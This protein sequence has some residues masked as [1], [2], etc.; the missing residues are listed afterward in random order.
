MIASEY[1]GLTINISG[2][3][4]D[5]VSNNPLV[6]VFVAY[7]RDTVYQ[8]WSPLNHLPDGIHDWAFIVGARPSIDHRID[9][10]I[11]IALIPI[12]LFSHEYRFV[13]LSSIENLAADS[14]R[15]PS[16]K[17]KATEDATP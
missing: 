13:E 8:R 11:Q 5:L 3:N 4:K 9:L 6:G 15:A 17:T 7:D 10:Y 14:F 16:A 1:T 12:L 2:E